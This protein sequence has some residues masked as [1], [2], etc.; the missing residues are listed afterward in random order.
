MHK[1]DFDMDK[2]VHRHIWSLQGLEESVGGE[3]KL[4]PHR[5]L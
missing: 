4:L 5:R 3:G 2:T 1:I